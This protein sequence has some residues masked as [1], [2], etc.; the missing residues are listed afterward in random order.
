M[1]G[2]RAGGVGLAVLLSLAACA[3]TQ[4][5]VA[6][7]FARTAQQWPVSGHSP[8]WFGEPVRFGP[9]SALERAESGTFGWRLPVGAV[10]VGGSA[11][12]FGFTLVAIGRPP[13]E[14]QCRVASL[15]LGHDDFHGRVASRLEVD[16]T[17]LAGPALGC[18][19]RYDDGGDVSLL[20][21]ARNGVHLDGGLGT[22]WGDASVRSL[23]AVEGAVAGTYAP[24]GF[25]VALHGRPVMVVDVVNAGRVLLDP[26]L[27]EDQRAY[28]AAVA[29][30]LLLLG[31]DAEA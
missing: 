18:G 4:L 27:D 6:P 17:G 25:E 9:Y 29:A 13:M 26:G 3:T 1:T 24:A 30:A 16:L 19:L 2:W 23:H 28:F 11:R 14:V 12:D 21:L 20:E 8:R 22:P 31:D 7:E 10:D 5:Q 15:V